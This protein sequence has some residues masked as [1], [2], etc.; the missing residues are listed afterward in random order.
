[1]RLLWRQAVFSNNQDLLKNRRCVTKRSLF[2][3]K[4]SPATLKASMFLEMQSYYR[5]HFGTMPFACGLR[6]KL[7]P[8][9]RLVMKKKRLQL[10]QFCFLKMYPISFRI[11]KYRYSSVV[12]IARDGVTTLIVLCM[13]A[14]GIGLK[15]VQLAILVNRSVASPP[16]QS[17]PSNFLTYIFIKIFNFFISGWDFAPT[18]PV[19]QTSHIVK[20]NR[21]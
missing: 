3:R 15:A 10:T 17:N 8:Q 4:K 7:P 6:V 5:R 16:P 20:H 12:S 2:G 18:P 13:C 9:G 1:M 21:L 19:N 14:S 11:F